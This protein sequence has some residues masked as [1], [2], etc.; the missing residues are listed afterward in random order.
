M[1]LHE[2]DGLKIQYLSVSSGILAPN[3]AARFPYLYITN[4]FYLNSQF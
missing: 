2:V 4:A 1:A 3:Y